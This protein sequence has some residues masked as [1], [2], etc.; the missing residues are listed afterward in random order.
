MSPLSSRVR[1]AIKTALAMTLAYGVALW[2]DWDRAYWAAFAVAACSLGSVGAS[3]N[4]A[5][6]RMFGTLL[7]G[8]VALMLIA[9]APQERWDF[10]LLVSAWVGF[11]TYRMGASRHAYFW[12][13][14]AFVTLVICFSGGAN[15]A[16]AFDIA[17]LRLQETGLG[18]LAYGL[19]TSLLWPTNAAADF[20]AAL[21]K[22]ASTRLQLYRAYLE[23]MQNPD[24]ETDTR[25][26]RAQ[27]VQLQ[28]RVDQLLQAA[29]VDTYEVWE[30]RH[31]WRRF[32]QLAAELAGTMERWRHAFSEVQNLDLGALL[33]NL[34]AFA[35]ELEQR[36]IETERMLRGEAPER[37]PLPIELTFDEKALE[38]LPHFQRAALI[39]TRIRL[40]RLEALSRSVFEVV[41]DIKGFGPRV[42]EPAHAGAPGPGFT[43]DR[44][45]LAAAAR[46]LIGLIL[47]YLVWIYTLVPGGDSFVIIAGVF[48]IAMAPMA[49]VPVSVLVGPLAIAVSFASVLYI[50]VL[51][52]LTTF[53]E[54]GGLIFAAT[55]IICYLFHKPQQGLSRSIGLAMFVLIAAIDN[56]QSYTFLHVANTATMLALGVALLWGVAVIT[57]SPR[58]EIGFLRRLDRFFTSCEYLVSRPWSPGAKLT[59]FERWR[60]AFHAREVASLPAKLAPWSTGIDKAL[61]GA[62][63]GQ[64]QSV[65]ASLQALADRV[66]EWVAARE[67][68]QAQ[69]IAK[70]LSDDV[71]E[72]RG[73]LQGVFKSYETEAADVLKERLNARLAHLEKRI[74]EAVNKAAVEADDHEAENLYRVLGA[75][76]GVSEAALA[77]A[78]AVGGIDWGRWREAR[79]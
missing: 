24:S 51:P 50:F 78:H 6:M 9:V 36:F 43:I 8:A 70:E 29:I 21:R 47:A 11:C 63:P 31:L 69:L 44:D 4:Q 30:V 48:G 18:I 37:R 53:T 16:N 14:A 65:L 59:R 46:A 3:L 64:L 13:V 12:F 54:I 32:R 73:K 55:F 45:L 76:R 61:P 27:G 33:P 71:S 25:E 39:V 75:Y 15:S 57:T 1:E 7:A 34:P 26:L 35:A 20:D 56:Q 62:A 19:V 17:I 72:W 67:L 42:A 60:R 40:Q 74:E 2:M 41:Q 68:P 10:I 77:Y 52:E 22:L 49:H 23:I 38:A 5:A 58:P 79:F 28:K 66:Q